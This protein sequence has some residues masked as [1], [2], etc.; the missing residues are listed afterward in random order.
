MVS[1]SVL[2]SLLVDY[3]FAASV[4][5][6]SSFNATEH[7]LDANINPGQLTISRRKPSYIGPALAQ[8]WDKLGNL[9]KE[10]QQKGRLNNLEKREFG[11]ARKLI[12]LSNIVR[13]T[14]KNQYLFERY[15]FYGCHCIPGY[16]IHDSAA[17]KGAPQDGIDSTC[18]NLRQCYL[19][20][21]NEEKD[22]QDKECDGVTM[23]YSW[24]FLDNDNDGKTDDIQCLNQ[25]NSCR[26]KL[27]Q[28]DRQFALELR[29]HEE[30]Y[31][32]EFSEEAGF[33]REGICTAGP[34]GPETIRKCCGNYKNNFRL[35]YNAQHQECCS[36]SMGDIRPIGECA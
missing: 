31:N 10:Y 11:T 32:Q 5:A 34:P 29:N 20:A 7:L 21:N 19:C 9:Y 3:G 15:C 17:G 30:E 6:I 14:Q 35:I 33:D 26:W 13:A 2:L 1:S 23:S 8:T 4:P 24:K 22:N 18:S 25:E 16:P 36:D 28:C 12:Q 27:C